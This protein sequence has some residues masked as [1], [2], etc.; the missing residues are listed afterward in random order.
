[1]EKKASMKITTGFCSVTLLLA[2]APLGRAAIVL[3]GDFVNGTTTPT[4]TITEDIV[5]NITATA[6]AESLICD[7]WTTSDGVHDVAFQDP[8]GQSLAYLI[9]NTPGLKLIGGAYD[10]LAVNYGE[11]TPNDGYLYLKAS[12]PGTRSSSKRDPSPSQAMA[13]STPF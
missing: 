4:L 11:F 10:N 13:I 8:G 6:W 12:P 3:S 9:N 7:E 1:M 5:F 2:A